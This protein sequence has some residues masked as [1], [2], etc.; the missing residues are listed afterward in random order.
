MTGSTIVVERRRTGWDVVLGLLTVAAG[1]VM[2]AHV[3]IASVVSVLFMGWMLL[4]AG[5]MLVL[6]AILGW[7][8]AGAQRWDLPAGVVLTILGLGFV[9]NPAA[10]LLVLTLLAGSVMLIGGCL[11]IFAAFQ[12]QAPRAVLLIN[13]VLT[14]LL[15]GM[16]LLRWPVSALWFL[17][18]VLGIQ[19]IVDGVTT[20]T[21]GRFRPVRIDRTSPA[22][23]A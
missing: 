13:G 12:P 9:R 17:G 22:V 6:S 1:I 16:I 20:T 15:G 5:V 21:V 8:D 14:L 4:L 23:E 11:R 18:T 2:L 7:K 3:V 19:L 10:A